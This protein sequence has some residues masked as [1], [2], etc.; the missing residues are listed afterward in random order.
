MPSTSSRGLG[1]KA[2]GLARGDKGGMVWRKMRRGFQKVG[3]M[4]LEASR[5]NEKFN[6]G[7]PRRIGKLHM[8]G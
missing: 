1:G 2:E 7:G 4:L 3:E 8:Q 6:S 5:V